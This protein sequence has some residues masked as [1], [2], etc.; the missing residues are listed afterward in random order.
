MSRLARC[1]AAC[2]AAAGRLAAARALASAGVSPAPGSRS[3]MDPLQ[4][5][6]PAVAPYARPLAGTVPSRRAFH[7]FHP[8]SPATCSK[9]YVSEKHNLEPYSALSSTTETAQNAVRNWAY[10]LT[11]RCVSRAA[12]PQGKVHPVSTRS[13]PRSPNRRAVT[14]LPKPAPAR[15]SYDDARLDSRARMPLCTTNQLLSHH[16]RPLH[17]P[18]PPGAPSGNPGGPPGGPVRHSVTG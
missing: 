11:A 9:V 18:F 15:P 14:R 10:L 8:F 1:L 7:G 6:L 17:S 13:P 4:Q 2:R 16:M 12:A 3:S 5:Y